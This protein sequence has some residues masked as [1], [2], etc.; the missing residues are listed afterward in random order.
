MAIKNINQGHN[1]VDGYVYFNVPKE[2]L[3]QEK[4][5]LFKGIKRYD[6]ACVEVIA[7]EFRGIHS[8]KEIAEMYCRGGPV[9]T[10]QKKNEILDFCV[11]NEMVFRYLWR[12]GG[13]LLSI[14]IL[15]IEDAL[16]FKLKFA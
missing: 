12:K 11:Q 7:P 14:Q 13:G 9:I 10:K 5:T 8:D 4:P 2:D 15:G 6:F 16:A 3:K 1:H